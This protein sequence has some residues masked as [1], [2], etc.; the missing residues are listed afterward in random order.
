MAKGNKAESAAITDYEREKGAASPSRQ[1]PAATLSLR[2]SKGSPQPPFPRGN[3]TPQGTHQA[4]ANSE[5]AFF[6][7]HRF[8][9]ETPG[10]LVRRFFIRPFPR[11]NGATAPTRPSPITSAIIH[12][13]FNAYPFS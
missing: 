13:A 5:L 7:G 2:L 10:V 8:H 3:D 6:D 9:V 1:H 12:S 11:G 4:E